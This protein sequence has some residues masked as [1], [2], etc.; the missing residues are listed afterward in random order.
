MA[1]ADRPAPVLI[2]DDDG[3]FRARVA[4]VLSRA[5]LDVLETATGDDALAAGV[6]RPAAIVLEVVLPDA[7]GFEL[8]RELRDRHGESLPVIMVSGERTT[9]HDRVAGLLVGADDYLVKPINF[10]ELLIRLRRLLRRGPAFLAAGPANG[11]GVLS[12]RER[13][14]LCLFAEGLS[15]PA[16][17][18]R[19]VISRKTVASHLQHVMA[20][21]GVHSRAHA[22]AEAYR[23][24]L[25]GDRSPG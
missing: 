15:A 3:D 4:R 22:V 24:G 25:V 11:E 6:D 20:K 1:V 7:D 18:E 12:P 8:C 16:I 14:V 23:I 5:G 19:L 17:A 10:D 13:E 2:V 21:L 9:A